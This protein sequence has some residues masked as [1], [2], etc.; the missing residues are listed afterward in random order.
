MTHTDMFDQASDHTTSK[1]RL[2]V[3]LASN[4]TGWQKSNYH[5]K[6]AKNKIVVVCPMR[7]QTRE[8][9]KMGMRRWLS[10]R[11]LANQ[12]NG[13]CTIPGLH[14]RSMTMLEARLSADH[15]D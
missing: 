14:T 10:E 2:F 5:E 6:Q 7:R 1:A 15:R 3:R 12:T 8:D 11:T 13:V 9:I 4:D